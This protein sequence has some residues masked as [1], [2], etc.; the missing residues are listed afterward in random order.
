MGEG[1]DDRVDV[2]G[3]QQQ[4]G[5]PGFGVVADGD[6]V[7]DIDVGAHRGQGGA[8]DTDIDL[9][10]EACQIVDGVVGWKSQ[11]IGSPP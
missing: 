9:A 11:V 4:S 10:V 2:A 8:A 5:L 3:V 6:D 7:V 1:D